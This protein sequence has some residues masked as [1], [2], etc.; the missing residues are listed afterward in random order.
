MKNLFDFGMS[1]EDPLSEQSVLNIQTGDSVLSL[2]S[3]GEVSQRSPWL[4]RKSSSSS[5]TG[6]SFKA[7]QLNRLS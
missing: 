7:S 5:I 4:F 6:D 3:G 2:A 1:Q